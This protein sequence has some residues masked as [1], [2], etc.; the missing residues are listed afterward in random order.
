M[1]IPLVIIGGGVIG[2]S[3]AQEI[4]RKYPKLEIALFEK[5]LYL[6]EHSTHRN[7]GV[8]HAGLYYEKNSLKHL[9]CIKG[10]DLWHSENGPF[11]N[12]CGKYLVAT[13]QEEIIELERLYD[14]AKDNGVKEIS[15]CEN[16]D[17]KPL[18]QFLNV[19][20]AFFSKK[21]SILNIPLY[22]K[23]L[24][25]KLQSESF[26]LLKNQKIKKI[27]YKNN[28]FHLETDLES[29]TCDHLVNAAGL[30][31]IEIRKMLGLSDL[32][33]HYVKGN[34]LKLKKK[35]YNKSLIYPVPLPGL[36]GLGVHTSFGEDGLIRFGPNTE[37]VQGV[38]YS[39][40]ENLIDQMYPEIS[41]IFK[42]I[43]KGDLERDFCGIRPKIKLRGKIYNDFWIKSGEDYGL[44]NYFELCG[45][46]SPGLTSAPAIAKYL[47]ELIEFHF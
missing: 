44:K 23:D 46:E 47:T 10:N 36:K 6:G 2:L 29:V 39:Q 27:T 21:T 20:K 11:V 30:G 40:R 15:W 3:I 43:S 5:E 4:Q 16:E 34:Y 8:L 17:L 24:E 14:R 22:L 28:I 38:D 42:S 18:Q 19:R 1:H 41:K 26:Y 32:E 7:S 37:D 13:N 25:I 12:N 45:I 35:Y 9:L 31:A 33:N